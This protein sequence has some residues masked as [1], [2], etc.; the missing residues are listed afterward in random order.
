MLNKT[1]DLLIFFWTDV[2]K[3]A[4]TTCPGN[5]EEYA[6]SAVNYTTIQLPTINA[7]DNSGQQPLIDCSGIRDKYYIG[8]HAITCIARDGSGNENTC[9]FRIQVRCKYSPINWLLITVC[10]INPHTVVSLV[11]IMFWHVEAFV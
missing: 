8:E 1:Y 5:L 3:P 2:E 4:F 10:L 6:D 7:T 11:T 9:Q